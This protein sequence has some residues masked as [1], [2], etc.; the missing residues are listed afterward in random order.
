M[1]G[2]S[3]SMLECGKVASVTSLELENS[4]EL[5]PTWHSR[6]PDLEHI[7]C[8]IRITCNTKPQAHSIG[9][10]ESRDFLHHLQRSA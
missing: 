7:T 9:I 8:H 4:L 3:W 6:G 1:V 5:E 10:C 2:L